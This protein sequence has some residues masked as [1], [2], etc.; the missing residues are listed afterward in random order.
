MFGLSSLYYFL[1]PPRA[2]K[3]ITTAAVAVAVVNPAMAANPDVNVNVDADADADAGPPAKK[4]KKDHAPAAASPAP[5]TEQDFEALLAVERPN[6]PFAERVTLQPNHK[7]DASKIREGMLLCRPARIVV[8]GKN[9]TGTT[10]TARVRNQDIH[11]ASPGQGDWE[12]GTALIETQ[13]WNA[14][15][16]TDVRHEPMTAIAAILRD[17][18]GDVICK[19]EFTKEPAATKMR[20][21][22]MKG[23]A[24]IEQVY[25]H[26]TPTSKAAAYKRLYERTQR[27]E[28]RIMR[29]YILRDADMSTQETETGMIKFLDADLMA[30]GKYAQR[31]VN[32][33]NIQALTF[34]GV[35]Y[36]RR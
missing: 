4:A 21:L 27:G 11:A 10:A 8:M 34:K 23:A 33:R 15:Q 24:I 18:V 20:D 30:Q 26:A 14:D 35:R 17:R 1:M 19:V 12:L 32:L 13:C 6:D 16:Y 29:G 36:E 7:T 22:L 28:Y 5:F 31:Q 9:N 25:A 2:K 3:L